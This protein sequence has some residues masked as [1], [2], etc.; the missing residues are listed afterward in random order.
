MFNWDKFKNDKVAV[1]CDTEEKAREFVDE[2]Y[3]NNITWGKGRIKEPK[4]DFYKE[5]TCYNFEI[6]LYNSRLMFTE[7]SYYKEQNYKIIKWESGNMKFK[8]GDKVR[9]VSAGQI[10]PHYKEKFDELANNINLALWEYGFSSKLVNGTIATI[11]A[12]DNK[13]K[14]ALVEGY[15]EGEERSWLIGF[16]GIEFVE[17][18]TEFTF[19]EVIA[20]IKPGE[21][22]VSTKGLEFEAKIDLVNEGL[23]IRYFKDGS[24]ISRMNAGFVITHQNKFKLQEP[25][26]QVTIYGVA[27]KQNGKMYDF[28][29]SQRLQ[30]GMFVVCDTSQGKSY[31]RIICL[32]DKELTDE[33]YKQHKECWRA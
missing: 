19:Q 23:R 14:I 12:L 18:Q 15:F 17:L 2:C 20:R 5:N 33:E 6:D 26:K 3:K 8:V 16:K 10:F 21:V 9:V 4:F 27:H 22:Y 32:V 28:V 24:C 1:W 7:K 29:S 31:G 25:K 13:E 30:E 11:R